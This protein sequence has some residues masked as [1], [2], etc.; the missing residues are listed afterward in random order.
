VEDFALSAE[1]IRI[2]VGQRAS[3]META[4]ANARI[5]SDQLK[6]TMVEVRQAPW[7]ILAAPTGRKELENEVLY[8]S[9]RAYASA[10]SD[11]RAAAASLD[12][13]TQ[14]N[15]RALRE[16]DRETIDRITKEVQGAFERY[17]KAERA[18]LKRW[19]GER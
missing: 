18:F 19:A 13:M 8:D 12:A 11:L 4:I 9:V 16:A 14:D 7:K 1:R 15:T 2:L 17:E 6:L 10:V 5:A 3:D